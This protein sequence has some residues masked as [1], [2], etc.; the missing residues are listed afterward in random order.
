MNKLK[1]TFYGIASSS[2]FGLIP[3]FT[4]PLMKNGLGFHSILFYRYFLASLFLV[5]ILLYKK[6]PLSL[7]LKELATVFFLSIF[8]MLAAL[9]LFQGYGSLSSGVATTIHFLYPVF[10]AIIMMCFFHEKKSLPVFLS[11]GLAITGVAF[12]SLSEGGAG[13]FSLFG[14]TIVALSALAYALYLVGI[15][16][17][18]ARNINALKFTFYI[19]L[20]GSAQFLVLSLLSQ[21]F[22]YITRGGDL[23]N[24]SLLALLPTVIS[25]ITLVYAI[26][27]IGSTM[28]AVL[29]AMEAVT[30]VVIGILIFN[31]PFSL[32]LLIGLCCVIA[33]VNIIIL[34][35]YFQQKSKK[36]PTPLPI[37]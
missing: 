25:N 32:F 14:V 2:T 3:L 31:E 10:V 36:N 7:S 12:L 37:K 24:V 23:L 17:T 27:H 30:A 21:D 8:S 22:Q 28:T 13:S 11:I 6:M 1:G 34:S 35:A 15:N 26:S 33:A 9:F 4:L 18:S 16:K 20:M 19:M 29:G 5:L